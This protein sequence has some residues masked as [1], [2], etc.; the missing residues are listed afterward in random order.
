MTLNEKRKIFFFMFVLL[1]YWHRCMTSRSVDFTKYSI[2]VSECVNWIF[3]VVVSP[4]IL[5]NIHTNSHYY[6][7]MIVLNYCVVYRIPSFEFI[8]SNI[9]SGAVSIRKKRIFN[10]VAKQCTVHN[11]LWLDRI[12]QT[13]IY[14]PTE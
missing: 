9:S 13:T 2:F 6:D 7:I 14:N 12:K 4:Q 8:Y 10:T 5:F 3:V 1:F 11:T